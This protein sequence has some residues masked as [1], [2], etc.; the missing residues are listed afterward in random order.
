MLYPAQSLNAN[1]SLLLVRKWMKLRLDESIP[2]VLSAGTASLI[3]FPRIGNKRELPQPIRTAECSHI[4]WDGWKVSDFL[5]QS[6]WK[7]KL[8][9]IDCPLSR[10]NPKGG[11]I[12]KW[13]CE[14]VQEK[15]MFL[16]PHFYWFHCPLVLHFLVFIHSMYECM[17]LSSRRFEIRIWFKF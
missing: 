11:N 13:K 4:K 1:C 8:D 9:G 16:S 2:A 7:E 14:T 12:S 17:T 10:A 3:E 5:C 6:Q 15:F